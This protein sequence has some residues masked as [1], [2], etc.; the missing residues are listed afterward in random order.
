MA[1]AEFTDFFF[2]DKWRHFG[3]YQQFTIGF[4]RGY[5]WWHYWDCSKKRHH[6]INI[7]IC[8]LLPHDECT[9]RYLLNSTKW[10]LKFWLVLSWQITSYGKRESSLFNNIIYLHVNGIYNI[11]NISVPTTCRVRKL[12]PY[13]PLSVN[14][15]TTLISYVSHNVRHVQCPKRV[16]FKPVVSVTS[17]FKYVSSSPFY[18]ILV[19]ILLNTFSF[20]QSA[21]AILVCNI[22]SILALSL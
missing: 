8:G 10:L 3:R 14:T 17:N 7:F 19:A 4:S 1:S 15:S 9:S 20:A 5:C 6:Y 11:S 2:L 21:K 18:T 13:I 16:S 12:S 22:F